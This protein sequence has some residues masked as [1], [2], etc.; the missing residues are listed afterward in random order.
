MTPNYLNTFVAAACLVIS[1]ACC[2]VTAAQGNAIFAAL[3]GMM[4][5]QA[6][7]DLCNEHEP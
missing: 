6:A 3:F 2:L 5:L 7:R 1:F 4:V